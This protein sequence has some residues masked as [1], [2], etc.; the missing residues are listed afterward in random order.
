MSS[1]HD[2]IWSLSGTLEQWLY[3]PRGE[4][5]GF[6]LMER[7]D[8]AQVVVSPRD[9]HTVIGLKIG[10]QITVEAVHEVYGPKDEA[11]HG[12]YHFVAFTRARGAHLQ[13]GR[14]AHSGKVA[15]FNYAKHGQRNGVV[16]DTGHFIHTKPHG[17]A[18]LDLKVG[19]TVSAIGEARPLFDGA[20]MVVEADEVNGM[21]LHET[22][23]ACQAA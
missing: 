17:I 11:A 23:E 2:D 21:A 5:Q 9:V 14:A 13:L 10:Q 12:L 3:G 4:L 15:R 19:D 8:E 6:L 16:L 7:G 18:L 22:Y 1:L 20:G